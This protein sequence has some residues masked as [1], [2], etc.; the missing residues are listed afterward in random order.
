MCELNW[1]CEVNVW[2]VG[3][4]ARICR[5]SA[6]DWQRRKISS[7]EDDILWGPK[8]LRP[9]AP[10]PP[11]SEPRVPHG[12]HFTKEN[13][14]S[15]RVWLCRSFSRLS[16]GSRLRPP[17]MPTEHSPG[18]R[19]HSSRTLKS[20]TTHTF[21]SHIQFNSHMYLTHLPHTFTSHIQLTHSI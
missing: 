7:P 1:M 13:K 21:T 18:L 4:P 3:K 5:D 10:N 20:L 2:V 12:L 11:F 6:P 17:E 15:E 19:I 8:K 9:G 14:Y 16:A